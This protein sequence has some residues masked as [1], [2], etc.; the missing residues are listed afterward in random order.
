MANPSLG[1]AVIGAGMV[2]RAHANAYRHAA[3]RVRPGP[4]GRAA[5][6]DR[7]RVRAVRGRDRA[8]VRLRAGRDR[9]GRRSPRAA[10]STWS[11]S[12]SPTPCTARSSRACSRPASTCSARSRWRRAS[13]TARRW[14]PRPTAADRV[15]RDRAH[16]P[17]LARDQRD[18]RPG[19]R[20][21]R[22]ARCSTSPATTGATTA[23]TRNAPMSWRYRGG[24]GL[25]R[26][27]RHRQPPGRPRRVL[28]RPD[29]RRSPAR[30]LHDGVRT[31]RCRSASAVGHAGGVASAT[32]AS[33]WRTRT[34]A[35]F[36][37]TFAGGAV[38]TFS[39]S[40]IAYGH[41]NTLRFEVACER[42]GAAFNLDRAG[43]VQHRRRRAGRGRLNGTAR[44]SSGPAPV[45][46]RRPADGLPRRRPRAERLLRLPGPRVPGAGRRPDRLPPC[47]SWPTACTTCG[48][49]PRSPLRG[50]P[51]APPSTVH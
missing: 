50:R 29:R 9:A 31:G 18:P 4:A 14:S 2:G 37:A 3:H 19:P 44:C 33:R 42:G 5:G 11:A 12:R 6:R 21:R 43:R 35:T 23:P 36:T 49:S 46:G 39:V 22:S 24:P 25:R 48:C 34:S 40:R 30:V 41:A 13:P 7:R 15:S 20:R 8:P 51:A 10:T 17:P 45:P 47:P 32:S 26:A 27:R 28:L 38:G 16:L 1:V